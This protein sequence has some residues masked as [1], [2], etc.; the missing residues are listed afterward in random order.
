M[1]AL[2]MKTN[3]MAVLGEGVQK[4]LKQIRFNK[5]KQTAALLLKINSATSTIELEEEYDG[6]YSIEELA[7]ELPE[8][9]PRYLVYSHVHHHDDDRVSYPLV[10]IYYKPGGC[11]PEQM[12]RYAGSRNYFVE[13]SKINKTFDLGDK[14]SFTEEWLLEKLKLK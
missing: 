11:K 1:A 7:E 3:Q 6:E 12:V 9:Q 4:K 14:E 2:S 5:T 13:Q 10:F 8:C